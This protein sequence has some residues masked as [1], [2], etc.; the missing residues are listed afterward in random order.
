MDIHPP[1]GPTHSLRDFAIHIAVV[2]VGI[3]IALSLEG[4]RE[5][6][7]EHTIVREARE[8]FHQEAVANHKNI[9][10][11]LANTRGMKKQIDAILKDR[12]QFEQHPEQLAPRIAEIQPSLYFFSSAR[13]ESALSTGALGHMD[14]TEV[15]NYAGVNLLVHTYTNIENETM[16]IQIDL[17]AYFAA[18]P[19]LTPAEIDTGIEK[20]IVL[21]AYVQ[22]MS[23]VGEELSASL[24]DVLRKQ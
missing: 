20:L 6:W 9:D 1:E 19:K 23:H 21:K 4:I 8:S 7:R 3:L 14:P 24:D 16:P 13:W 12:A 18:H 22:I 17:D 5:T 11:E 10:R 2:T 15:D